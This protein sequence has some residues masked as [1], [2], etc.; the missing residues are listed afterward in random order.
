[1]GHVLRIQIELERYPQIGRR[2]G[3]ELPADDA[4]NQLWL[5]IKLDSGADDLG[6]APKR[7]FHRP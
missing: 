5:A 1:M 7:L 2:I 4:D 6:V 3:D